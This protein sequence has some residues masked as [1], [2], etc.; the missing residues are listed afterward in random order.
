MSGQ[1]SPTRKQAISFRRGVRAELGRL[2]R[3]PHELAREVAG[4][5]PDYLLRILRGQYPLTLRAATLI[6]L[7]LVALGGNPMEIRVRERE[8]KKEGV[9]A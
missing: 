1:K 4:Y 9:A 6:N 2:G 5:Y 3:K 8:P 7:G